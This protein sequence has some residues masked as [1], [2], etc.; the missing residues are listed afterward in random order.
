MI[1]F[2][3]KK[4]ERVYLRALKFIFT[5]LIIFILSIVVY[6]F[7]P[8]SSDRLIYFPKK[9]NKLFCKY[10][11]NQEIPVNDLDCYILKNYINVKSG[12]IRT[13][14]YI[15]KFDLF[16]FASKSKIE[17]TRTMIVYAGE[18]LDDL[19]Y[20]IAKQAN[21]DSKKIKEIYKKLALFKDGAIVARKYKIPYNVTESSVISYMLSKSEEIFRTFSSKLESEEFKKKL[22]I[23]SIVQK[24]T[25]KKEEMPLISSVI[26]N[27]LKKGI[28]LQMDATLNYGKNS[29]KIITS[30][31]IKNDNSLYNTYKIKGLP[32]T[33]ICFVNESA[34]LSAYYPADTDYL[35]F[36]KGKRGH[37][38]SDKYTTHKKYVKKYKHSL[39][40]KRVNKILENGVT[41]N[42]PSPIFLPTI[43]TVKLK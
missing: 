6:L 39:Y 2:Y 21:L 12:W 11:Q 35:Y 41:I 28:K 10:L 3:I 18:T 32:P 20:K 33:P 9:N 36:V 19:A 25:Q 4:V 23:A 14:G 1:S 37:K 40:S 17:K 5:I 38:F 16:N 34:L 13:S 22:I 24:E 42:L 15:N 27:R 7:I 26:Y 30:A 8:R 43:P 31:F 29:H